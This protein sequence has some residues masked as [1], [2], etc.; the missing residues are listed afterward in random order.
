[1]QGLCEQSGL[2]CV[3]R[4]AADLPPLQTDPGKLKVVLKNL[5]SNAVKFTTEGSVTVEAQAVRGGVEFGVTD[6]GI[7][8]PADAFS[9]IFEPFRQVDSS[10]TRPYSGSGLGLHI[11]QRL[12]EVLSG[13]I[14]VESEVGKGST[15]RVW[16]P[17][18]KP[19]DI[20]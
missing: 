7:G 20:P 10:D 6:T 1:M 19:R 16:L 14:T 13:T 3:W 9:F 4:V 5:L 12:L 15:F 8:I 2:A 11:V 17:S 18:G